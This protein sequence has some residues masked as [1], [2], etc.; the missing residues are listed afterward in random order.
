VISNFKSKATSLAGFNPSGNAEDKTL[1]YKMVIKCSD[2]SNASKS[3][4]YYERWANLVL[5]EFYRQGDKEKEL[6][7]PVSPFSDSNNTNMPSSQIGFINFICIPLYET[8]NLYQPVPEMLEKLQKSRSIWTAKLETAVGRSATSYSRQSSKT[9]APSLR[10]SKI[11]ISGTSNAEVIVKKPTGSNP[12]LSNTWHS[13]K[14]KKAVT[15]ETNI[16][17]HSVLRYPAEIRSAD[18]T[19]NEELRN[20]HSDGELNSSAKASE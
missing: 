16:R 5:E 2:V 17:R 11:S 3:F 4:D 1:L 15:V 18:S 7:I 19:D 8:M 13:G 10:I 9:I 14:M 12:E 6:G 20:S